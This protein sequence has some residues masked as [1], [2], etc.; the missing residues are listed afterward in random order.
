MPPGTTELPEAGHRPA[1]AALCGI[2]VLDPAYGP[3]VALTPL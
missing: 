2:K 3:L 1:D